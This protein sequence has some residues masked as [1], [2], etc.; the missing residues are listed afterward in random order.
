MM[1]LGFPKREHLK[2]KKIFESLF[3]KGDSL[4]KYPLK[5]VYVKADLPKGVDF[6]VGVSVPKKKFKSAV[7]RNHIKRLVR[8]A[9]RLN[10]PMAH[11]NIPSGFAFLFIY[12]GNEVP[13]FK[14]VEGRMKS[15]IQQ[16]NQLPHVQKSE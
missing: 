12:I 8:E 5:L 10:K 13:T 2:R 16:F 15:I 1:N 6:Q 7:K 9:Y 3:E 11:D 14:E 4:K